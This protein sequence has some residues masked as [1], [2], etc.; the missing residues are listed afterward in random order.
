M[1]LILNGSEAISGN[2]GVISVRTGLME[3]DRSYLSGTYLGEDLPEGTYVYLEVS[4]TG[5]GMTVETRAR[6]FEA[7]FTT[8]LAGRGLGL[9]AVLGIVR[10]HRGAVKVY[11]E[12]GLGTTFRVLFPASKRAATAPPL[13]A[14]ERE[15]WRD[16]GT[17]LVVDDEAVV[18]ELVGELFKG[19][20]FT[21]LTATDGREA[22]EVFRA[23]SDQIRFVL[24]DMTMP[25][26]DGRETFEALQEIRDDVPVILSSGFNEQYAR[27][28]FPGKSPA[29]FIQKPYALN[30]L[31]EVVRKVLS[32]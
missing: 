13:I 23:N 18:R 1:N 15:T 31:L 22:V 27:S 21:V 3:C 16:T 8:K 7:F 26:M 19:T 4:D 14:E 6:L 9:A 28:R 2:S 25:H 24:L 30:R 10:G 17:A 29:E 32:T 12:A 5:C 11:S 20:G